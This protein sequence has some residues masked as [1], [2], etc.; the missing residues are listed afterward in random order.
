LEEFQRT[1]GARGFTVLEFP[2]NQFLQELGSSEAIGEYCSAT[3][4]VSFPIFETIRVNG[5]SHHPLYAE[6][7]KLPDAQGKA[8]RLKWNFEKFLVT[9]AGDVFRF[10]PP[11][12]PDEPE[13]V[14]RIDESLPR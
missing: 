14:A 2:S 7:V 11:M 4:G 3:W 5:R 12:R 9:Q 13:I 8:G 6:L 10:R 1:Y